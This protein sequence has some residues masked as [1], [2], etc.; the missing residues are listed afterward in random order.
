MTMRICLSL[1]VVAATSVSCA[2]KNA[3]VEQSAPA[4][5]A[6]IEAAP[7]AEDP[8]REARNLFKARCVVCHGEQ[9]KGDGPGAAA[10]DPKPRNFTDA[11]WQAAATDEQIRNVIVLGGAGANKS[12]NM[13]GNPDLE[14]K[15]AVVEEL[16]KQ[17][18]A[19]RS[20]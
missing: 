12:P 1:F 7:A 4:T 14:G 3:D 9:G 11:T 2:K 18:R 15:P 17:V 16:V 10:L 8:A 5:A 6:P 19:H 20:N 13:P